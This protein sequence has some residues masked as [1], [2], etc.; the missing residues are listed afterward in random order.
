MRIAGLLA[1][2]AL[3]ACAPVETAQVSKSG[4]TLVIDEAALVIPQ[5]AVKRPDPVKRKNSE[6]ARDFMELSFAMESGETL[7][8]ISR[9]EGPILIG[10]AGDVPASAEKDLASLIGRLQ[11]EA[12]L[13]VSA[14]QPGQ[15]PSIL[16]EFHP[17]SALRRLAPSAACF[18]VP[19]VS[20]LAE[21]RTLR[22]SDE[23]DWSKIGVRKKVAIFLPRDT[24]PQEIR[25]CLHEEI[26]QAIGP[27]N[28]L[29]R[30]PDS[31]FNDDNFNTVLTAFDMLMLRIYNA[32]GLRSGMKPAE[33]AAVL[34]KL[35]ATL[36][37]G[38]A[39]S[40]ADSLGLTPA[41]WTDAIEISLGRKGS[42][43]ARRGAAKKALAIARAEG[44]TD[45]RLAF[46]HFANARL[47]MGSDRP[48][49]ISEFSTAAAIYSRQ[50]GGEVH[51]AHIEM[52]LAAIALASGQPEETI[53]LADRAIPVVQR[54]E[55]PA[56]LAT[57]MLLKA[58]A[59]QQIGQTAEA[60]ALRLD[61][62]P[63]ALYGFGPESI[64]TIRMREIAT[65]GARAVKG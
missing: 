5:T 41:A 39:A 31:V 32:P 2:L 65:V 49:A 17:K 59:L 29:Y 35:I 44:W 19:N 18:V 34:P 64:V 38:G 13:D 3:V 11:T 30:L 10:L 40:E 43:A 9:F 20:S 47:Y 33:V 27:L 60:E 16:V 12:D 54:Y 1:S 21:Y 7:S 52:Q 8:A 51:V 46:S 6:I 28:D 37:P 50:K 45:G 15:T 36:N 55:N 42:L 61:S 58:E 25:D 57:L 48:R 22:G 63:W 56:L 62:A 24:S 26:A 23:V 14:A 4:P 53:A